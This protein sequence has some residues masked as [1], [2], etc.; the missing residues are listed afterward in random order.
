[1]ER[2]KRIRSGCRKAGK[3]RCTQNP[4]CVWNDDTGCRRVTTEHLRNP[5]RCTRITKTGCDA[6]PRCE[7]VRKTHPYCRVRPGGPLVTRAATAPTRDV[8]DEKSAVPDK[9]NMLDHVYLDENDNLAWSYGDSVGYLQNDRGNYAQ[10]TGNAQ[11]LASL[12]SSMLPFL[13]ALSLKSKKGR[14]AQSAPPVS[15]LP[16]VSPPAD[17]APPE[18]FLPPV[19][20]PLLN[21]K[22]EEASTAP[23][24]RAFEQEMSRPP[25]LNRRDE[26]YLANLLHNLESFQQRPPVRAP[27]VRRSPRRRYEEEDVPSFLP[28]PEREY[29]R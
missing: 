18:S 6:N 14:A 10:N 26:E 11:Q 25:L 22:Q 5:A 12:A 23:P 15:F 3:A 19:A 29:R 13:G 16:P 17:N 24:Q 1:M 9:F 2:V 7:W 28:P 4:N 20:P 21:P 27:R 8:K